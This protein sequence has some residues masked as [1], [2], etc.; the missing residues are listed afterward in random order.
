MTN[1]I[2]NEVDYIVSIR[3]SKFQ[4]YQSKNQN[5]GI[6]KLFVSSLWNDYPEFEMFTKMFCIIQTLERYCLERAF[7]KIK[8]RGGMC[9]PCCVLHLA[10]ENA[11]Y[12]YGLEVENNR[13]PLNWFR[14]M[15]NLLKKIIEDWEFIEDQIDIDQCETFK[16]YHIPRVRLLFRNNQIIGKIKDRERGGYP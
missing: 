13:N 2:K 7:Q 8:I 1:S 9:K 15:N 11:T 4:G 12:L 10:D 5:I 6:I 16:D 14:N 3:N